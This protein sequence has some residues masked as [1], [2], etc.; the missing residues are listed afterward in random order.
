MQKL[1][2]KSTGNSHLPQV[3]KVVLMMDPL[4]VG[5]EAVRLVC[6]VFYISAKAIEEFSFKQLSAEKKN[7]PMMTFYYLF[8]TERDKPY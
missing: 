7:R 2:G 3:V 5:L 1:I 6:D 8:K 4:V